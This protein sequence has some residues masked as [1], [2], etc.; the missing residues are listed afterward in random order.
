MQ[1]HSSGTWMGPS[2]SESQPHLP[3]TETNT[4][5]QESIMSRNM[6]KNPPHSYLFNFIHH[7]V[8]IKSI[9]K[10][11][12]EV[13]SGPSPTTK[14]VQGPLKG[15]WADL[16][17]LNSFHQ[18]PHHWHKALPRS[19]L[20]N[21]QVSASLPIPDC[22]A[23]W[24]AQQDSPKPVVLHCPTTIWEYLIEPLFLLWLLQAS[25]PPGAADNSLNPWDMT[26]VKQHCHQP[27]ATSPSPICPSNIITQ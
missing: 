24:E 19:H 17:S 9:W 1:S 6:H 18:L 20:E 10:R 3:T 7:T 8:A 25:R 13:E 23:L 26:D 22:E 12:G 2:D 5:L 27:L 11:G 14:A 16:P 21:I 15:Q 4:G